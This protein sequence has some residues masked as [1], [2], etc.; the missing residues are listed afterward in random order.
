MQQTSR[1]LLCFKP[2]VTGAGSLIRDVRRKYE[3]V[4]I[5]LFLIANVN[6]SELNA[7]NDSSDCI[8]PA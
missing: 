8:K 1:L 7:K 3:N 2:G 5:T 6:G 4:Q